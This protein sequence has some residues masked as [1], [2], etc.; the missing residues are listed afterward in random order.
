[1]SGY[2]GIQSTLNIKGRD[3][4]YGQLMMGVGIVVMLGVLLAVAF[5]KNV[6]TSLVVLSWVGIGLTLIGYGFKVFTSK[7]FNP[8]EL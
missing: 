7:K 1:M 4:N 3:V 2:G 6:P 5:E 8:F